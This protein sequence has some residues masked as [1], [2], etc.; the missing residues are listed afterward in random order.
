MFSRRASSS[1]SCTTS[2]CSVPSKTSTRCYAISLTPGRTL[3]GKQ[4]P[5]TFHGKKLFQ[6]NWYTR[7]LNTTDRSP[8][9][10]LHRDDFSANRLKKLRRDI[11]VASQK[12][13]KKAEEAGQVI[14]TPTLTVVRSSI[15]GAA[16]REYPDVNIEDVQKLVD[17]VSGGYAVLSLPV[18]DPPLLNAVLRAMDRSVPPRPEKTAEEIAREIAE[19]SADP[20]QPGRRMKRQRAVLVP[21][22]KVMGALLEGK[23]LLPAR[24]QEV[25][26][27]P[28]LDTLRAQIVGL[29]T[30]PSAQ[31]AAVMSQASGGQ[32]ARTLEG[33][34]KALEDGE[35]P[36]KAP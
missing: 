13:L 23:V 9:I 29:L 2:W 28:P 8:L 20:A 6:Y 14:E 11:Q 16:L 5:R 15:F 25:S 33:F 24:M 10:F 35:A 32:L 12:Y 19:K 18:L 34:K 4:Y 21:D 7:I 30:A 27:F 1:K 26:K 31:L 22:L 36:E 17:G 3:P